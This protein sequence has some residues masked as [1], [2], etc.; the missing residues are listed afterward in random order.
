MKMRRILLKKHLLLRL[1]AAALGALILAGV[2]AGQDQSKKDTNYLAV[3]K[4]LKLSG[5]SQFLFAGWDEGV[6]SFSVRR[7]RL[8][9]SGDI[10]KNIRFKVQADL[11]KSP[12]LLDAIV[13]YEYSKALG[14]RAGQFLLPFS[15]EN[16]TSVSDLDTINRSQPEEKL[17][18]GRD[19]S[20]Q[21]RDVGIALFGSGT[22]FEYTL[23]VF[24][25]AGINKADLN[26]HKDIG[27]RLVLRPT[28]FLALGGSFYKGKQG[29]T[30][31]APLLVRDKYGLEIVLARDPFSLKG[32]YIRS[33]DDV[34]SRDGWYLQGG[35]FIKAKT[36]QAVLKY[37]QWDKNRAVASDRMNLMTAGINWFL[38]GRTKLQVNYE[39]YKLEGGK[40][41]NSALLV[42][43]QAAF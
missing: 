17:A 25:G 1:G 21:G 14:L 27:G 34:V 23:G 24:N 19:N 43:F 8:S 28:G 16:L 20:A 42:Q 5:A 35:W 2:S 38:S 40:T 33:K 7:L 3:G 4:A 26:S 36:L 29:L 11:T 6:D 30:A 15:L 9:L 22:G 37:D 41:D 32:E 13:E 39:L 12:L 31:D 18:P 10:L